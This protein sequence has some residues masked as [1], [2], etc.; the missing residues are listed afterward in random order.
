MDGMGLPVS[1]LGLEIDLAQVSVVSQFAEWVKE[2]AGT[3]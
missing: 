1:E 3:R 2:A